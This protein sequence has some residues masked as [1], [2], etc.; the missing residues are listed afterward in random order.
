MVDSDAAC[1]DR[2]VTLNYIANATIN[3]YPPHIDVCAGRTITIHIVPRADPATNP[4]RSSSV[5]GNPSPVGWLNKTSVDG[6]SIDL[7]VPG[8]EDVTIPSTYKYS[9]SIQG[10]GTIDPTIR[11]VR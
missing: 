10:V 6:A 11:I 3:V 9:L 5:E 1:H 7:V 4:V 2:I 8:P